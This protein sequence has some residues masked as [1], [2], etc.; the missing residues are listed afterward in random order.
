M[1]KTAENVDVHRMARIAAGDEGAMAELYDAHAD[2]VWTIARSLLGD[3]GAAREVVQDTFVAVWRDAARFDP[4][5]S[6]PATWIT[7]VARARTIDRLRRD[8]AA[9]RGGGSAPADID[10]LAEQVPTA[11][12]A[13]PLVAEAAAAREQLAAALGQLPASQRVLIELVFLHGYS[14][15]ELSTRLDI[16]LGTIKTRVFRG[17]DRLRELLDPH[18]PMT[19]HT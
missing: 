13:V 4:Y 8:R 6:Q 7:R 2:R 18:T 17:L 5:R 19:E 11:D 3:D 12:V 15:S 16:P 10:E 14:H 1:M 9:S